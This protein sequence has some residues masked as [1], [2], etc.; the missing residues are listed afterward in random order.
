[1]KRTQA[2]RSADT[3]AKVLEA[4]VQCLVERGYA[5]TTTAEVLARADVPRG[6]LLH[7]FPTKVDLLVG[8]VH[9]VTGRRVESLTAELAAIPPEADRLDALIDIIWRHFSSPLFWAALELWN[10]CRTDTELRAALL[11]VEK[12]IF[13]V[14]H[15]RARDLLSESS[16]GDPRVPTVVEFSYEVLTGLALTG[17]VSGDLGRRELLIRRWK[18]AAAILLGHRDPST[19]VE[20]ARSKES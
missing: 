15:D 18:R 4:T 12:E 10:A 6:T 11:P 20:R 1:M 19:L 7:H 8:A 2:Q 3:R 9:H 13:T 16:P 14:L 5:E 17:I